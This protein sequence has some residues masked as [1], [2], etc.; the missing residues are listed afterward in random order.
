MRT[1][2][3]TSRYFLGKRRNKTLDTVE[4]R[5]KMGVVIVTCQSMRMKHETDKRKK[6]EIVELAGTP[7]FTGII[8]YPCPLRKTRR[9]Y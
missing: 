8:D 5:C 6:D 7:L 4:A 3:Y 9:D 1:I 2:Y